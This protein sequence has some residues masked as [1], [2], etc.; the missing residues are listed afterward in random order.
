MFPDSLSYREVLKIL[1]EA[2]KLVGHAAKIPHTVDGLQRMDCAIRTHLSQIAIRISIEIAKY[3]AVFDEYNRVRQIME[4]RNVGPKDHTIL[5]EH[6]DLS[7]IRPL[8]IPTGPR[9]SFRGRVGRAVAAVFPSRVNALPLL[10]DTVSDKLIHS[11]AYLRFETL[12]DTIP[13]SQNSV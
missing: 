2:N 12:V 8:H 5:E 13:V 3:D 1:D 9:N 10:S 6:V 7:T 11:F 4:T